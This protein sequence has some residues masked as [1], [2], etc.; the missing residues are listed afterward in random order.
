M[1]WEVHTRAVP[2]RFLG[3]AYKNSWEEEGLPQMAG[4]GDSGLG[5]PTDGDSR[6]TSE[7]TRCP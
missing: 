4:M 7:S 2:L 3:L 6:W 1:T 5:R